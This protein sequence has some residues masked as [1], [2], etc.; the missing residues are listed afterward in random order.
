MSGNLGSPSGDQSVDRRRRLAESDGPPSG[1]VRAI[2]I[3]SS[4]LN[5]SALV[6][7]F[8]RVLPTARPSADGWRR[9]LSGSEAL[10]PKAGCGSGPYNS[11]G[12]R[13]GGGGTGLQ[14]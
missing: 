4:K 7:K 13:M 10:I 12:G 9:T 8:G 2:S 14:I 3:A 6:S 5:A 11:Q 1:T